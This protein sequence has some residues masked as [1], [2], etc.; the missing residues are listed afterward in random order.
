MLD[1]ISNGFALRKKSSAIDPQET[2]NKS[3]TDM[4]YPIMVSAISAESAEVINQ[5]EVDDYIQNN[6]DKDYIV[7]D[8]SW[9]DK[10]SVV[11]SADIAENQAEKQIGAADLLRNECGF[12]PESLMKTQIIESVQSSCQGFSV[13]ANYVL[14]H[15][16]SNDDINDIADGNIPIET[17]KLHIELWM[18]KGMPHYSGRP[19]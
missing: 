16:L 10:D 13:S 19:E 7:R 9:F 4:S 17:L 15:L 3:A 6:D 18:A 12:S 5:H 8:H 2:H 1:L 14:E 11:D